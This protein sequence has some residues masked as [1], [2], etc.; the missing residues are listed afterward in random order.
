MVENMNPVN[1][2]EIPV[3]DM[4]KARKFYESVFGI[5]LSMNEMGPMKMAWFPMS[6]NS[7]GSTGS[8]VKAEGYMPSN[9][10]VIVYFSVIDIEATLKTINA[11]GGKTLMPKTQI[12]EYGFVA[13][14][15][16]CEGNHLALHT[17]PVKA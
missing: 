3:V 8:L 13:H 1:W 5:N 6:Q 16:D 15:E 17:M 12:G 9:K 2:F 14:F 10:G 7:P 11:S 4:E